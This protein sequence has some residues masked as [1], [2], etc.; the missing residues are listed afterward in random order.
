[1]LGLKLI[2]WVTFLDLALANNGEKSFFLKLLDMKKLSS[3]TALSDRSGIFISYY[4]QTL[5]HFNEENKKTWNQR[6][7]VNTEFFNGTE[8]APVFLLIGGEGTASDSWMKYGAWYGYAKEVGAL[9]IQLEHRFYGSSRPTENMSTEN[10]KF[11]TSQQAL[12]DIVEFI[13]FAKQQYSLNETNKWVTF[14]GSYPGSLSLWMRSLYPELISGALSSSAPVEVKVDFEEYLGVVENDMNI[15]D[16]KCVPEVKKAIQQIQALIVSAPDGWK[17]VAKI[18]SL[19]DGWS[20]DN[21]QDLR[22]F[23]ASVLGAFYS[24]AQ[25]DSVLNNDDLAHMCPYMSN[26]YFGDSSLERLASTLKGKYGGSCLNVNYKDLLDF[27]TTEEWAHGEDVGYRQWVYQTCNEFGWYQ[28]GNI[29]GSFFPVEF[30]TQ[31]CRD[32]YGM[33]F[34]D[35]IIA[36][37]ANY[38]NIMYGS[39]NPPLSNTIITHGSFDPWHPMGILEDMSE[40]VKTFIING[41][42]HCYDLYPPNPLSDSEE[43]TRARNITF[44][45]IKRWIK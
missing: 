3:P 1:M 39:K 13:R 5:D 42:S 22:S 11:L 40:S 21:I 36:S 26:E 33:D 43:L 12:E 30:Y 17:K 35:E 6:Y 19:C 2:A 10:L 15:R 8:T 9:M 4:N 45:H 34:T 18:F 24:S 27:M 38:T 41:T 32:V 25:Y 44:E 14:G 31:Q 16:P 20:G 28:T 37:N 7:F 23:Y 29:W